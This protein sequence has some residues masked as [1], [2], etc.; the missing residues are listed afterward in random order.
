M[1]L[2]RQEILKRIKEKEIIIKPFNKNNIGP[3]SVDLTLDNK[4]R[5][6]KGKDIDLKKA[7][8]KKLTNLVK[9]DKII[10]EPGQFMLGITKEKIKL[11][12]NLMGILQGR[13]RYARLGL[14]IHITAA[15]VQP[16]INNKQVLEIKNVGN[17]KLTIYNGM[18]ICQLALLEIKGKARYSGVFK[19]QI[20][21]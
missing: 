19:N 16:G 8:Y 17:N 7:D 3:A 20:N 6:F 14:A 1:I 10:L 18:K 5:I 12:E 13:S 2:S 15:F 11:P 9:K 21:L 4:F